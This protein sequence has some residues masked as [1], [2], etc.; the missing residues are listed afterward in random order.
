MTLGSRDAVEVKGS[1]EG[2][3]RRPQAEL[4]A[5]APRA[6]GGDRPLPSPRGEGASSSPSSASLR[7]RQEEGDS[8]KECLQRRPLS[9]VSAPAPGPAVLP[10]RNNGGS[11]RGTELRAGTLVEGRRSRGSR[12]AGLGVT[13]ARAG[14]GGNRWGEAAAITVGYDPFGSGGGTESVTCDSVRKAGKG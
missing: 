7:R 6:E 14:P 11:S 5:A 3:G 4:I 8:G 1:K 2:P 9:G 13:W 12:W 10:R